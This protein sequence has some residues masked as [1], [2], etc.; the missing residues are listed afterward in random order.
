MRR[1]LNSYAWFVVVATL[2]LISIGGHVTTKGAGLAVPDWPLS[3]GELNPPGWWELPAVRLEHGHRLVGALIGLLTLGLAGWTFALV[4]DRFARGLVIIAVVVVIIQGVLGGLRVNLVS[5]NL[6]IFHGCLGQAF[7][8]ILAGCAM[9]L[10]W[11]TRRKPFAE[12]G[13]RLSRA[14]ALACVSFPLVVFMQLI[15]AAIMRHNH[16]GMAIPDFPLAFGQVIPPLTT[17]P[18]AIHFA[19]RVLAFGIAVIVIS[20][21]FIGALRYRQLRWLVVSSVLLVACQIA[22]GAGIILTGRN[23]TITTLHVVTGATVLLVAFMTGVRAWILEQATPAVS[24][25]QSS[26]K[27]SVFAPLAAP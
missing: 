5:T 20:L 15:V 18:V 9:R 24:A 11:I 25:Q 14:L 16:A 22:L 26:S 6:A 10:H 12:P 2:V 8:L 13:P 21:P 17:F 27:R 23:A 7:L 19:H 1:A 4:Q 3:F